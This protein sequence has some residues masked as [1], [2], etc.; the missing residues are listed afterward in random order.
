MLCLKKKPDENSDDKLA[1]SNIIKLD[2]V[3]H[4]TNRHTD[5]S[6]KYS[7]RKKHI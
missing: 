3:H 5:K 2:I 1:S 7:I 4:G 6:T